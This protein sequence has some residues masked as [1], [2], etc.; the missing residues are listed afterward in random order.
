MIYFYLLRDQFGSVWKSNYTQNLITGFA[1]LESD[2]SS[3][4]P[5]FVDYGSKLALEMSL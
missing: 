1:T 2:S 5:P 4:F 3:K